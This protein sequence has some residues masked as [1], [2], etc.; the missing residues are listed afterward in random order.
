MFENCW[1]FQ[2]AEMS[3]LLL[4]VLSVKP[5]AAQNTT[6]N[7]VLLFSNCIDVDFGIPSWTKVQSA[8]L[9][10]FDRYV[11]CGGRQDVF[12]SRSKRPA[13]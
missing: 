3:K 6:E 4:Y 11:L 9:Q 13:L 5:S 1:E 2:T 12:R 10:L 7:A 8:E